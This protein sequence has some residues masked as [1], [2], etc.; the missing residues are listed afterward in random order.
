MEC[1]LQ[2]FV[3]KYKKLGWCCDSRSYCIWHMGY[4]CRSLPG[5]AVV[6]RRVQLFTV[7][8]WSLLLIPLSV[9]SDCWV[10]CQLFRQV[11][12]FSVMYM[13]PKL[14]YKI[15]GKKSAMCVL[16][17]DFTVHLT[18]N[19]C[20]EMNSKSPPRNMTVQLS[21]H[22]LI[23]NTTTQSVTDRWTERWQ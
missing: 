22:T 3:C 1:W 9:F 20:K 16:Y 2:L 19:V 13:H 21:S 6:S 14:C 7:S 15:L 23:M 10:S 4:N 5:T 11:L 8:N 17:W 18:A 12:T